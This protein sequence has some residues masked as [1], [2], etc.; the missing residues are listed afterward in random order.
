[1][2]QCSKCSQEQPLDN[3]LIDKRRGIPYSMCKS[4]RREKAKLWR[5]KRPDYE[6][7]VYARSKEKTRER[8]LLRKYG[9]SLAQYAEMLDQQK[10][11]C[12]ICLTPEAKQFKAV[13]HVDHCHITGEVRGLLCRGCNHMLGV[14]RDDVK[15]L[16]RAVDYLSSRKSRKSSSKNSSALSPKSKK[17]REAE[18]A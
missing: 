10:G 6:K 2:K 9:V 11:A 1:M 17:I 4:C 12:A 14:V 16:H 5:A 7:L 3:F 13:L 8:H 15:L 18:H